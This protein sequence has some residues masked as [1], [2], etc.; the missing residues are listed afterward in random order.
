MSLNS[1]KTDPALGKQVEDYL[2][3]IGVNTPMV[4]VKDSS[5]EK[6][7]YIQ[8]HMHAILS[9]MGLDMT[10]DSLS[11]TPRRVAKMFINEIFWGLDYRNFPRM[12]TIDNK[13]DCDEM[14]VENGITIYSDCEHHIR[15]IV[16][17]A[18]VAYI[19]NKKVLG[20]SKMARV[21]EYFSRRPQ[22]QE[23]LTSQIFHSLQ[24]ILDTDNVAVHISAMHLCVAQR[25]VEDTQ[26]S[27]ITNKF[28]GS[29]KNKA[30]TRAEFFTS[31]RSNT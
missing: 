4:G 28:G 16:G 9:K 26:A 14:I 8:E 23:R 15:P 6:I 13:M 31:I 29:F 22:V 27:T 10:D 18:A 30:A 3:N 1:H 20:I 19:P 5:D 17:K 2:T 11:G 21:C 24:Y 25:G 12:M 7:S